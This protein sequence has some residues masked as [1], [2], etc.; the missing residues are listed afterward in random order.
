MDVTFNLITGLYTP[1]KKPHDSLLYINTLSDYP[2]PKNKQLRNSIN[3]RLCGNS[4]NK[5]VFNTIKPEYENA[6]HTSGYKSSLKCSE[7][8]HQYISKKKE[9]E[10]SYGLIHNFLKPLKLT[11]QNH[12][13]EY[14][15]NIFPSLTQYIRFLIETPTKL[16]IVV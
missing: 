6:L 3:K 7:E 9:P 16:V 14:W 10:T 13:S 12:S 15:I 11:R 2:R 8:I 4:T 5:K 1:F